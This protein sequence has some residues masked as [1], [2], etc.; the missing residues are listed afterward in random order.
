MDYSSDSS[1]NEPKP[2]LPSLRLTRQA[3]DELNSQFEE[4]ISR[5]ITTIT[6]WICLFG[7]FTLIPY[8]M[9]S[10]QKNR[11]SK[12]NHKKLKKSQ[13][14][15][16]ICLLVHTILSIIWWSLFFYSLNKD[17]DISFKDKKKIASLPTKP[18]S[19]K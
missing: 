9:A 1:V 14:I 2:E 10:K 19:K 16:W 4:D 5:K 15:Y 11:L 3:L 8:K 12:H 17:F 6:I 13:K 7:I 18:K